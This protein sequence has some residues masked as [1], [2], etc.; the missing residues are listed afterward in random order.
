MNNSVVLQNSLQFIWNWH[1]TGYLDF[2][3]LNK[4]RAIFCKVSSSVLRNCAVGMDGG[5]SSIRTEAIP[6]TKDWVKWDGMTRGALLDLAVDWAGVGC[7]AL[8]GTGSCCQEGMWKRKCGVWGQSKDYC[9]SFLQH[10]LRMLLVPFLMPSYTQF[11]KDRWTPSPIPALRGS[12]AHKT[13]RG[14]EAEEPPTTGG[15]IW[16]RL[17]L[18]DHC[19]Q[20]ATIHP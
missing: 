18:Q 16:S 12:E 4:L 15:A 3:L 8:L 6:G 11:L 7:K 19:K 9:A 2:Y 13:Q 5:T 10:Q 1:F 14:E 20:Q 17:A